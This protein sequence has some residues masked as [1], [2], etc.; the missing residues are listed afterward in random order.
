MI[1]CLWRNVILSALGLL[2]FSPIASATIPE[3]LPPMSYLDNGVIRVGVDLRMGGA[4]TWLSKSG[5]RINLINDYDRGREVQMSDYSGPIPY[6]PPG[7]QILPAWRSLGWNPVQ[8]G[9]AF[10]HASRVTYFQN[11][12]RS[13][14][15]RCIP[16]QWPLDD[17]PSHCTF[18]T[19][20]KLEGPA[21]YVSCVL[22]AFR[23]DHTQYQA[24]RQEMPALY[25]SSRFYRLFTYKGAKPFTHAPVSCLDP[26][27]RI[28]KALSATPSG[29][30]VLWASH[31]LM[32]EN[33]AAMVD[34]SGFGVGIW[35]PGS[36]SFASGFFGR[37]GLGNPHSYASGYMSPRQIELIDHNIR[38]AYRYILI[39]GTV[40]AIRQ[41][42][43]AHAHRVL[44]PVWRFDRCRRHWS[45]VHAHDT[46]WPIKGHLNISLAQGD[47]EMIGPVAFW[48]ASQNPV[49]YIDAK[50]TGAHGAARVFWRGIDT[51]GFS[52]GNSLTFPI[53]GDGHY[54]IYAIRLAASNTYRGAMIQLRV[55]P[56]LDW[57]GRP[58]AWCAVRSIGFMSPRK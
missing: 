2:V 43:Y 15:V 16:M 48:Q 45:Y 29:L 13:L 51:P 26:A 42:V 8:A 24:V 20:L 38:F 17:V 46:G 27:S 36:Y 58:D 37:P 6:I 53:R 11:S 25:T 33:W 9:D 12:G 57:R 4:I 35:E 41:Y 56:V 52:A 1:G 32:T 44:S 14:V 21:V 49:L 31:A 39:V 19:Q 22:R 18:E 3:K 47:P 55:D 34:K 54:H 30:P 28:A 10:G 7:K 50:F 23:K 5:D 40:K